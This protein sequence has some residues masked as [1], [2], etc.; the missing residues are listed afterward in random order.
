MF[1]TIVLQVPKAFYYSSIK[2]VVQV[3][4]A[5]LN[6]KGSNVH[7]RPVRTGQASQAM[8]WTVMAAEL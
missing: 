4:S 6:R 3:H 5:R 7:I 8:A 2:A 1:C